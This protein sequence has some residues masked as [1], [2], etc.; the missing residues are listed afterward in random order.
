MANWKKRTAWFLTAVLFGVLAAAAG[1]GNRGARTSGGS[2]AGALHTETTE[3]AAAAEGSSEPDIS[4]ADGGEAEERRVAHPQL[5][6]LGKKTVNLDAEELLDSVWLYGDYDELIPQDPGMAGRYPGLAS[7]LLASGHDLRENA[8]RN[9]E[10]LGSTAKAMDP[11]DLEDIGGLCATGKVFLIRTDTNTVSF[12]QHLQK[13]GNDDSQMET[14][15]TKIGVNLDPETGENLAL[16]D[17]V[18]DLGTFR[19]LYQEKAAEALGCDSGDGQLSAELDRL[20]GDGSAPST[21]EFSFTA[22]HEGMYCYLNTGKSFTFAGRGE[23]SIPF[24]LAFSDHPEVFT[25]RAKN[26]TDRW[27]EDLDCTLSGAGPER[28]YGHFVGSRK[29]SGLGVKYRLDED[30]DVYAPA[31]L[32]GDRS[33]GL[34]NIEELGFYGLDA[35]VARVKPGKSVLCLTL[36]AANDACIFQTYDPENA[37]AFIGRAEGTP[38]SLDEDGGPVL[39]DPENFRLN[40]ISQMLGTATVYRDYRL[41]P[42]SGEILAKEEDYLYTEDNDA[43]TLKK[44]LS[45]DHAEARNARGSVSYENTGE[46]V[47]IPAGETV[48]RRATDEKNRVIL[49]RA[50]GTFAAVTVDDRASWP[51]TIGGTD[52][53]EIFDGLYFAG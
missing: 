30:G 2:G 37:G 29:L 13:R 32:I 41:D 34:E 38:E 18:A 39:T 42:S 17:F 8:E 9:R 26:T 27:V 22:G 33:F 1:C 44:P 4:H 6:P 52:V 11:D 45:G 48:K 21:A 3:E 15:D 40:M 25:D 7:A 53:E 31:L 10:E 24:F 14:A 16:R 47:E 51:V 5:I 23:T 46:A 43:L 35:A 19:G 50:D 28:A 36:H 20:I 12:Q 49:E